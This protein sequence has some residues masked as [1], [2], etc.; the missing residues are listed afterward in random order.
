MKM[1]SRDGLKVKCL[2]AIVISFMS[3]RDGPSKSLLLF[4]AVCNFATSLRFVVSHYDNKESTQSCYASCGTLQFFATASE[5][6]FLCLA[7]DLI[8]AVKNPFSS[9]EKRIVKYHIVCWSVSA[10]FTIMN[11]TVDDGLDCRW[12]D[13]YVEDDVCWIHR[14]FTNSHRYHFAVYIPLFVV[15]VSVIYVMFEVYRH[16]ANGMARNFR[17]R[18]EMLLW[19]LVNLG[20]Y[21]LY[22]L[23]SSVLF[24]VAIRLEVRDRQA[25]SKEMW[26]LLWF[27]VSSRG[28]A[29]LVVLICISHGYALKSVDKPSV[30]NYKSLLRE[31]VLHYATTGIRE[32][33]AKRI[34]DSKTNVIALHMSP[35]DARVPI[36][37]ALGQ[38]LFNGTLPAFIEGSLNPGKRGEFDTETSEVLLDEDSRLSDRLSSLFTPWY[39][40]EVPEDFDCPDDDVADHVRLSRTSAV[41][42]STGQYFDRVITSEMIFY[43][44][45]F[46]QW[47]GKV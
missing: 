43:M 6:W 39:T 16:L 3:M 21:I 28:Y 34:E 38:V 20:I 1:Y 19:N 23:I 25:M 2:Q 36:F 45:I 14:R 30:V 46:E 42:S 13:D 4:R 10:F 8:Q 7:Y 41:S 44:S 9:H 22:W 33:S 27:F 31:Q 32:S 12:H 47:Q 37:T 26:R 35:K 24:A 17:S 5:M 18:A 15:I 11:T 40:K 29:D